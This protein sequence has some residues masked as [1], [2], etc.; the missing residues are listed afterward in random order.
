[1]WLLPILIVGLAVG[2]SVPLGRFMA[3]V[4]DRPEATNRVERLLDTGPQ[5][6]RFPLN[7]PVPDKLES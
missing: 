1:M 3:H 5:N 7:C 4:L 2:L 6:R